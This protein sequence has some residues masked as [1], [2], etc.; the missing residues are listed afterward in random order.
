MKNTKPTRVLNKNWLEVALT[1]AIKTVAQTA[2][3]LMTVGMAISDISWLNVLSVSLVAG[4][5]S[6]L[7]TLATGINEG[8][9]EEDGELQIDLTGPRELYHLAVDQDPAEL[10]ERKSVRFKVNTTANLNK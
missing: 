5:I 6:I 8:E 3:G 9:L 4:L 2:L 1:R 7:T 10:V